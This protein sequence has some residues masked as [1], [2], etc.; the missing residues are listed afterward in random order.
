MKQK[1]IYLIAAALCLIGSAC[2]SHEE[3]N[4]PYSKYKGPWL[5]S[6]EEEF[7]GIHNDSEDFLSWYNKYYD[8]L[9]F[10]GGAFWV[11]Y[12]TGLEKMMINSPE[13]LMDY[14]SISAVGYV[15]WAFILQT[16]TIKELEAMREEFESL[17]IIED[18]KRYD[19][20]TLSYR[21]LDGDWS[22]PN[23]PPLTSPSSVIPLDE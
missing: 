7:R 10:R 14:Y 22:I 20:F 5:V 13:Y 12:P 19:K 17:T 23:L 11:E 21:A 6:F 4:D 8:R 16:A 2:S 18:N 3:P 9:F 1:F 15:G